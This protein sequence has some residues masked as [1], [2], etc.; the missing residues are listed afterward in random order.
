MLRKFI[1][2]NSNR[3]VSRWLVFLIDTFI[4]TIAFSFAYILRFNFNLGIISW[5]EFQIH[6]VLVTLIYMICSFIFKSF[7][8]VIRHTSLNDAVKIFKSTGAAIVF[9][10]PISIYFRITEQTNSLFFIPTSIIITHF[11]ISVFT[12]LS[13]RVLFKLTYFRILERSVRKTRVLIYGAGQCGIIA[14]NTLLT[15]GKLNY[16][17]LGFIDDNSS[18]I[19]KEIEGLEIL[20]PEK[21]LGDFLTKKEISIVIIAIQNIS[22]QRKRRIIDACLE[23]NVTVKIVPA[24]EK[25]IDGEFSSNQ[26]K[27]VRIDDLL[28]REPISLD[29]ENIA[30]EVEG[31]V[32]LVTG[33]AGSIGSEIC[34]QI[35]HYKPKQLILLDQAESALYSI[36]FEL[37]QKHSDDFFD[38]F[39]AD[40]RNKERIRILFEKYKPEMVFHA[41]AYKHVP[42]MEN[43]P[44]EGVAVNV[45]GTKN[46]ADLSMEYNV[47]KFVMVSTDKAVNP[48]NVMGA[49]KR[50]AEIYIQ[51]LN[52]LST[53]K[54]KFITTRFG[55]VLG[56]NGSVI[57]LFRKQI[58]NGGPLLVTHEEI[59]RYFMTIPEACQ[60]V[61]EAGIMGEGGEIFVF[62]MG[63]SVRIYDL[64]KKMIQLS[65]LEVGTDIEIKF[66]GLRPGEKLY[67]ELLNVKENTM[68]THH[69]KIMK[70]QVRSYDF[71]EVKT[72]LNDL[73]EKLI[74]QND[75]EVVGGLKNIVPEYLSN[76]SIFEQLDAKKK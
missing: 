64:A 8:G 11:F 33:A 53:T 73:Q 50:V 48:T 66:T 58:E 51:S 14:K 3:F 74:I 35:M 72:S 26:I 55:N 42:M 45:F 22:P 43:H 28:G 62:D 67:E 12:L 21:A 25:W 34:R 39:I 30:H 69:P 68:E 20:S 56:S 19:G 52:F 75:L 4:I 23:H 27:N 13:T 24:V 16:K 36:E 44:V 1:L 37:K 32:I 10:L 49:T 41:A 29:K 47:D 15:D 54:T 17:I 61:L 31:K 65:G 18:K 2:N 7:S 76:N 57:P 6:L 63:D 59:T 71:E 60:L 46:I 9:L 70:G 38:I 40:I 5:K